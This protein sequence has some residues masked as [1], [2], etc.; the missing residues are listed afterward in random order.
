M[1]I[2]VEVHKLHAAKLAWRAAG[3][4]I[5]HLSTRVSSR[6][7]LHLHHRQVMT[8]IASPRPSLTISSRRTST[9]SNARSESV[10]RQPGAQRRNRAA[11]RE[12]YGL[13]E[14]VKT[15]DIDSKETIPTEDISPQSE[16]DSTGFDSERYVNTLLD[17][18]GLEGILKV[19][20][21]LLRDIRGFDGERKALVYDNYSKLIG[22]TDTIRKVSCTC[23]VHIA[24]TLALLTVGNCRCV[25]I[26]ILSSLPL[27]L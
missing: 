1:T 16:I 21:G 7:L 4:H 18:E 23:K 9:S 22:A 26:W 6:S 17:R 12:F 13:K 15:G 11:L 14:T 27:L 2:E 19:E 20:A 3:D 25:A 24:A 10:S 5:F 8:T